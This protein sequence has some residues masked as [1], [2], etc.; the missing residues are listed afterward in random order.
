MTFLDL[1]KTAQARQATCDL[2]SLSSL[3]RTFTPQTDVWDPVYARSQLEAAWS[4]ADAQTPPGCWTGLP[5]NV[6]Q[7]L[8][9]KL[10][11]IFD[12]LDEAFREEDA[13]ALEAALM[14]FRA[15]VLS[16]VIEFE[17]VRSEVRK[18]EEGDKRPRSS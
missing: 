17:Q 4:W 5:R 1:F 15:L 6:R 3:S 16:A 7:D 14:Q 8:Q 13:G 11:T 12:A 2:S 9:D 10:D 18:N